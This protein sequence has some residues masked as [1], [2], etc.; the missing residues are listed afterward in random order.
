VSGTRYEFGLQLAELE[1]DLL[2][3]GNSAP[4]VMSRALNRAGVSGKTA[5]ARAI[6]ASTGIRNKDISKEI[7]L[8]KANKTRTVVALQIT[9]RKLPLIAFKATGP[10]P[11][12]GRGA[13]VS[14][15]NQGTRKKEAH[16]FI[17]T[18]P[19]GHRGVFVLDKRKPARRGKRDKPHQGQLPIRE[20]LGPSLPHVF[21]NF[22]PVFEQAAAQSFANN[23]ARE[24]VFERSKQS[25]AD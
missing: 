10:E 5:M 25:A 7:V 16:A 9:G 24:I 13:G 6:A 20:L 3:L 15:T 12:R 19:G 4:L 11:S 17:A 21:E 8:E 22:L 23:L 2:S 1:Q 18:M 14:W